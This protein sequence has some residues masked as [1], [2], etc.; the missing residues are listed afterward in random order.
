MD[1]GT[2]RA[3]QNTFRDCSENGRR[4]TRF[5]DWYQLPPE[6]VRLFQRASNAIFG[7]VTKMLREWFPETNWMDEVQGSA[8]EVELQ[9]MLR[10]VAGNIKLHHRIGHHSVDIFIPEWN[11]AIEYQGI[12][13]YQGHWFGARNG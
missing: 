10:L 9:S 5:R 13:H 11:L 4:N 1:I 7:T 3:Q 12:Q 2:N 6:Q 8:P